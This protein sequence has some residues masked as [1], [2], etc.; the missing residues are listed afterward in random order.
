MCDT[1]EFAPSKCGPSD[2]CSSPQPC[3]VSFAENIK[4]YEIKISSLSVKYD[5]G[6]APPRLTSL[7]YEQQYVYVRFVHPMLGRIETV[8]S[9]LVKEAC[10]QSVCFKADIAVHVRSDSNS[11]WSAIKRQEMAVYV[12]IKNQVFDEIAGVTSV[13]IIETKRKDANTAGPGSGAIRNFHGPLVQPMPVPTPF[14]KG[15]LKVT[16]GVVDHGE[17]PHPKPPCGPTP[18]PIRFDSSRYFKSDLIDGVQRARARIEKHYRKQATYRPAEYGMRK[19]IMKIVDDTMSAIIS[20][21]MKKVIELSEDR[22]LLGLRRI[23]NAL[24]ECLRNAEDIRE[25]VTCDE[26]ARGAINRIFEHLHTMYKSFS[27]I[28]EYG[29]RKEIMK[30]VDDTMS[31]IISSEMKKV[32]EL[33]EDRT[34]LGLRRIENALA[35]CLRN[36]ED[37]REVVTCDETA[38]GAIN[39]IFEHLHTM[40][41]E[42]MDSNIRPSDGHLTYDTLSGLKMMQKLKGVAALQQDLLEQAARL[43]GYV[44]NEKPHELECFEAG[45]A[46]LA[47]V[48]IPGDLREIFNGDY[49]R[50][51]C[52][53]ALREDEPVKEDAYNFCEPGPKSMHVCP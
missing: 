43:R 34:L 44:E 49:H 15:F 48:H 46:E 29:M 30:I 35:E 6:D 13:P 39:R 53:T 18:P 21:E 47:A 28:T 32:I 23:E 52:E 12:F 10:G 31:A 40:Y 26:T 37:I 27:I 17:V 51:S 9:R 1:K 19:E 22:T 20:S 36:A 16:L 4:H 24:A 14:C 33:S 41:K 8:P 50:K 11:F 42:T 25:V 7:E 45:L 3:D 38:R 2:D 5:A